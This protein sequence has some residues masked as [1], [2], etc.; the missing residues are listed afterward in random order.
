VALPNMM[1]GRLYTPRVCAGRDC[2][3]PPHVTWVAT[4]D[5]H[6]FGRRWVAGEEM[7][8]CGRHEHD[9]MRWLSGNST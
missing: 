5:G 6:L 4:S 2:N 8:L 7:H 3:L 9:T 1:V